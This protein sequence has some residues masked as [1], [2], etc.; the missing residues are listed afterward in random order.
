MHLSK[1]DQ[2][3][4]CKTT[5]Q[6]N[7]KFIMRTAGH[8][9]AI[10]NNVKSWNVTHRRT[11]TLGIRLTYTVWPGTRK[12]NTIA[13]LFSCLSA[14]EQHNSVLSHLLIAFLK[15]QCANNNFNLHREPESEHILLTVLSSFGLDSLSECYKSVLNAAARLIYQRRKFDHVS[16]LL[17]EPHWLRVP[18]RITFRLAVLAYRCQH[19]TALRYLTAQLQQ[20]SNVVTGSVCASRRR[21]SSMFLAPNTLPLVAVRSVQLQLMCGTV[22]QRQCS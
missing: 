6:T 21:P 16:P 14:Q 7:K 9:L 10:S 22:C 20:A 17:K 12:N 8:R 3:A 1:M 5:H 15:P 19:N 11:R 13:R 4:A 18:E 2:H